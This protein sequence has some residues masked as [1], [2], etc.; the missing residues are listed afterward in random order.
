MNK[1]LKEVRKKLLTDFDFYS[2]SALKIRT[3][4]GKIHPLKIN[5]AQTI[6]N[7]AVNDQLSTEGKI[8]IIILKA[9]QQ[10]LSTYTGG[11]LYYSVSQQAARKAMVSLHWIL[12][13]KA[14][15]YL[16]LSSCKQEKLYYQLLT[17]ER[18]LKKFY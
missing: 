17:A 8:R 5:A 7:N 14:N 6:L 15:R 18:K 10:G 4:E 9:R 16:M 11:Y 12:N 1:Q 13:S 2:K 3:K